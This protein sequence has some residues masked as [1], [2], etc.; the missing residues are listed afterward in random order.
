[1]T[2]RS[3]LLAE[4]RRHEIVARG[5]ADLVVKIEGRRQRSNQS[6][7]SFQFPVDR[8]YMY[9]RLGSLP[10]FHHAP[11]ARRAACVTY[12]WILAS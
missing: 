10:L 1:M 9:V 11:T 8:A 5:F 12:Y 6:F 3:F 2:V 4:G 7:V